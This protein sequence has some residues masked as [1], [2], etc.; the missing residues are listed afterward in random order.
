MKGF[1][2]W[3]AG[4]LALM[5]SLGVQ[6][7][8]VAFLVWGPGSASVPA[9]EFTSY[10][11]VWARPENDLKIYAL[12]LS[13][14]LAVAMAFVLWWA[15]Q[16]R[17]L[18]TVAGESFM[19]S[20]AA[21]CGL[22]ACGSLLGFVSL[23]ASYWFSHDL[24][25]ARTV[26]R[27][28]AAPFDEARL[29]LPAMLALACAVLDLRLGFWRQKET[30]T[31]NLRCLRY[32]LP[33]FIVLVLAIPPGAADL[34][35]GGAFATDRCKHLSFFAMGPALSFA[36][37]K[38][39]GTEIYSQ[40]GVGWPL[41]AAGLNRFSALTFGNL[42]ALQAAYGCVYYVGLF[43]LLRSWFKN[44]I[45]AASGTLFAISAQVFSGVASSDI[46][47]I[48]PSVSPMRHPM[49]VW[50]FAA[51]WQ[52]LQGGK[53]RWAMLGGSACALGVFFETETGIY[54]ALTF[55]LYWMLRAGLARG[56]AGGADGVAARTQILSAGGTATAILFLLLL[57][58]SRGKLF[59]GAFWRGW[60]EGITAYAGRGISALPIAELP[61]APIVFFLLM[62]LVFL[63]VLGFGALRTWWRSASADEILLATF[64]AYG[65]AELTYFVNRSHP[66][67][68][69]VA[70][71]PL[72]V[73]L[74]ALLF[75]A[76]TAAG[77]WLGRSAMPNLLAAGMALFLLTKPEFRGYPGLLGSVFDD[78]PH[79]SLSL[80]RQPHDLTGI[81]M[82]YADLAQMIEGLARELK[83][84][85][86]DG[87]SV[88][89][90]DPAD[91][92]LYEATGA[93]PWSR[94][95]PFFEFAFTTRMLEDARRQLNDHPPKYVVT[96][97][98]GPS[99]KAYWESYDFVWS[100]L[101]EVV[102]NRF[103]LY[104]TVGVY[105]IWK[106]K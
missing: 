81:P 66:G 101:Y 3:L 76:W 54:L 98:R 25:N 73:V 29:L 72:A 57:C 58:A 33:L 83:A 43:F 44:E 2:L 106:Q 4:P 24:Q 84:A 17:R 20:T 30:G 104:R 1:Q 31:R 46:V 99:G 90:F 96:C 14:T 105:E 89:I 70:T 100:P 12:G 78:S 56:Q 68:L 82:D 28:P 59:T 86:P 32:V 47:W 16:I 39:F 9:N 88:A 74:T 55:G 91:T 45:W 49:D 42:I 50:F 5:L 80:I 64:A 62:V 103:E 87:Q 34:L 40:Y 6:V 94:Y 65:L 18:G 63:G 85:G 67:S 69:F 53:L 8:I 77:G 21:L 92:I 61:D 41:L 37:G 60:L 38:A 52:H 51:L 7:T 102:T 27:E 79:T 23:L 13:G 19:R 48:H 26:L 15:R 95:L 97:G 75:K 11:A 10:G 22:L 36:H 71:M 93:T 35:A